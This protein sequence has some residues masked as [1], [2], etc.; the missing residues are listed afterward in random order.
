MYNLRNG[1]TG[2]KLQLDSQQAQQQTTRRQAV[3]EMEVQ[4]RRIPLWMPMLKQIDEDFKLDF[5]HGAWFNEEPNLHVHFAVVGEEIQLRT[6]QALVALYGL[7]EREIEKWLPIA[8]RDNVL[9]CPGLRNGMEY[10]R[11]DFRIEKG[12]RVHLHSKKR[13]EIHAPGIHQAHI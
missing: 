8:Q 13:K 9:F 4:L 2:A 5:Y 12:K 6:V 11:I 1:F 10:D 7:F 3:M